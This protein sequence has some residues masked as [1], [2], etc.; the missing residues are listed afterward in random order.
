MFFD[1]ASEAHLR[2]KIGNEAKALERN[3]RRLITGNLFRS[4]R[5]SNRAIRELEPSHQG[6]RR[7]LIRSS[8]RRAPFCGTSVR[9]LRQSPTA[10]CLMD[11]AIDHCSSPVVLG[12]IQ[13]RATRARTVAAF[14]ALL[15]A[16][17]LQSD[18]LA[19]GAARPPAW[20]TKSWRKVA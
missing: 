15:V 18:R 19:V 10:R 8:A 2:G 7:S 11:L 12:E 1:A 16:T 20:R 17:P 9:P 4:N 14:F 6:I 13:D 3:S 5:E